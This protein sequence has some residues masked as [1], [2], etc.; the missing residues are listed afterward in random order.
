MEEAH[1]TETQILE[2]IHG[3]MNNMKTVMDSE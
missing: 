2:V 3:L 1:M